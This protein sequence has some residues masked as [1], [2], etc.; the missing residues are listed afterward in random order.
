MNSM[1]AVFTGKTVRRGF[2]SAARRSDLLTPLAAENETKGM[3]KYMKRGIQLSAL[4]LALC[5]LAGCGSQETSPE[6]ALQT[7]SNGTIAYVPLDDRPV[8][9]DRV[10]EL[11]ESLGYQVVMPDEALYH[12]CLDGQAL[13]PNGTQYGDR[14]ALFEWVLQQEAAGCHQ[15][16][17]SLDQLLSG[18]LVNSRSMTSQPVTL[19][20][21]TV[22]TEYGMIDRL[23]EVLGGSTE[24]RIY[25]LDTVM[26]LAPT[27]GYDGFDQ[28][29]YKAL[30]AYGM[31][32]RPTLS[33]SELTVDNIIANYELGSDGQPAVLFSTVPLPD[34]VIER[35]TEA[36][37]RKLKLSD[38]MLAAAK[39]MCNVHVL[40]GVD[41]SAP[42]ASIQ[43]SEIAYLK[44]AMA[45]QGSLLSGADEDGMLAVC[46]LYED[47][48]FTGDLPSV[49]VRYFGGSESAASSDYDHQP[50]TEIVEAHL[51]YLGLSQT[52]KN[53]D[54]QVLVLTAP[55][56]AAK[57]DSYCADLISVLRKNEKKGI[58][59]I[60]MDAAKN[61]YSTTFQS[62]LIS[63]ADLG[64][65]LGYAGFYDLANVTGIALSNGVAR[66]LCLRQQG[67]C[68]DTQNEAYLQTLSESLI[69]DIC[70]KNRAKIKLTSYVKDKLGGDPDNFATAGTDITKVLSELESTMAADTSDVLD[71]FARGNFISALNPYRETGLGGLSLSNYQ[72]PWQRVFEV[73]MKISVNDFTKSHNRF[74]FFEF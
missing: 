46:R 11:A 1:Q 45:G 3:D 47:T 71:N 23:L 22:L 57:A 15:F 53:A 31:K 16:I 36:R 48:V 73:R 35:Y 59:T 26:R 56:D 42:A 12:T 17:L 20:D 9:T 4:L 27:V 58:P 52:E 64:L 24:N 65:L 68:T 10:V 49:Q 34:D 7:V 67:T 61:G 43:T 19:S 32:A 8:N 21:G 33:G 55:A 6:P 60:L 2:P 74:L 54:L 25:L 28:G 50:L 37:A 40:I 70:Y 66:W 29:G 14:A 5:L 30:R 62:L 39:G 13:N 38:H 69:K 63:K 44:A 72:F 18:G 51:S 41:D